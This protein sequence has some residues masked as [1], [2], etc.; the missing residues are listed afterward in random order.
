MSERKEI[1][2]AV[3]TYLDGLYEGDADKLASVFHPTSV[4]TSDQDGKLF[5]LPRDEWLDRVRNRP[6][7]KA[8]GLSRH[9]EILQIDEAGPTTAFVKVKCAMPP[10]FFTD[11]LSFLKI[12]GRWQVAQKVFAERREE[13]RAA[14]E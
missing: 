2:K 14:A 12:D 1:E 11:Y 4:L 5:V 9:D 13:A 3:Q 8:Q 7:P 10:R 6:S